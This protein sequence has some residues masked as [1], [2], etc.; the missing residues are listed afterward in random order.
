VAAA[1]SSFQDRSQNR[2]SDP[3]SQPQSLS[4]RPLHKQHKHGERGEL[5]WRCSSQY[6][7]TKSGRISIFRRNSLQIESLVFDIITKQN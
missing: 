1:P 3:F 6:A 2:A 7:E 4:P 5:G